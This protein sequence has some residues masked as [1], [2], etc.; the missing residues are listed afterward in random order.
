MGGNETLEK[1]KSQRKSILG[2][3]PKEREIQAVYSKCYDPLE[4]LWSEGQLEASWEEGSLDNCSHRFPLFLFSSSRP[5][6]I[7]REEL[8]EYPGAGLGWGEGRLLSCS[9]VKAPQVEWNSWWSKVSRVFF[10]S[11]FLSLPSPPSPFL[12]R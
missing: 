8:Q 6:I 2:S 12:I 1:G 10:L 11:P 9:E 7:V 3:V 5:F 4:R